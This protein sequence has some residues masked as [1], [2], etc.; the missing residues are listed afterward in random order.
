MIL[1]EALSGCVC[2]LSVLVP[3]R[4]RACVLKTPSNIWESHLEYV[5]VGDQRCQAGLNPMWANSF[6]V[7]ATMSFHCDS[8]VSQ[9]LCLSALS[10][11][12]GSHFSSI[13]PDRC[14]WSLQR[15]FTL[16]TALANNVWCSVDQLFLSVAVPKY[17]LSSGSLSAQNNLFYVFT[18]LNKRILQRKCSPKNDN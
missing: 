12:H 10:L 18:S 5:N 8:T 16:L 13:Q 4:T 15:G 17:S 7:C 6:T 3:G 11:Q 9:K 1:L 2:Y 14:P